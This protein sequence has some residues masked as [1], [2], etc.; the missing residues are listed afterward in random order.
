MILIKLKLEKLTVNSKEQDLF[1]YYFNRQPSSA[2]VTLQ[3]TKQIKKSKKLR[4]IQFNQQL[5]ALINLT[6]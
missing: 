4:D 6:Y 5:I 3:E 1:A 2:I